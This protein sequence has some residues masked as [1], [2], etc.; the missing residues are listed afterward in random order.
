M[1]TKKVSPMAVTHPPAVAAHQAPRL[2]DKAMMNPVGQFM[3]DPRG[4]LTPE[5]QQMLRYLS[6]ATAQNRGGIP[7]P[8]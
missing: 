1:F 7:T 8:P 3:I 4:R 5:Q 2:W 6:A